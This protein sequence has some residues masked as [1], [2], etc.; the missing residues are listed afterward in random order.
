MANP[1]R[2]ALYWDL[3]CYPNFFLFGYLTDD[4]AFQGWKCYLSPEKPQFTG[5]ELQYLAWLAKT[6][7]WFS[8]NGLNY[9]AP[10][11]RYALT[12]ANTT[13]LKALNDA[14]IVGNLK[15]WEVER[16]GWPQAYVEDWD[17]VDIMEVLP[18]VKIGQKTYMARNHSKTLQD[19]PYPPGTVLTHAQQCDVWNYHNNDLSGLRELTGVVHARLDLRVRLSERYGVDLRSKS[20]AQMSE[21]IIAARLGYRPQVPY[22]L[23]GTRFKLI[24]APWLTFATPYM[25]QVHELCQQVEFE[26]NRKDPGEELP[27]GGKTGVAMPAELKKLRVRIGATDY[28]FGIGG[29]HSQETAR[30]LR[31]PGVRDSDVKAYYP[32]VLERMGLLDPVQQVIYNAIKDERNTHKARAQELEAAGLKGTPEHEEAETGSNGGKIV[33]NGFYG[34]L[35]SK[36]S[37]ALNPQAGVATTING[38]LSLL[39]LIER[40]ELGGVAVRSANTDGIVTHTPAG[41]EW[42]REHVMDWWQAATGFELEHTD[43]RLLAQRDVNSYVAVSTS[44]KIKRK[45]V[46]AESGILSGMQGIHPDRD[47]AKDA[48]VLYM[49][50][51]TPIEQTVRAC[52]DIRKFVLSRKVKGGAYHCGVYLG[53]TARWYYSAG[54][55]EP[56][57]YA[58]GNKV[59]ASDGAQPIQTLP[60]AFPQDVDYAAYIAYAHKL[61][62]D[63]GYVPA[64]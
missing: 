9:D 1:T 11:W 55:T 39:M 16:A 20:D 37:F 50:A 8:F 29:L 15:R 34:K 35:W 56:L 32:T 61:V 33:A 31:G 4:P 2:P 38:Q 36:Y 42:Y 18:G 41:L 22:L 19:L 14:I 47:I 12:G 49:T 59:A 13:Q 57:R 46:F 27:D 43:Y 28:K 53:P 45:G 26:F 62:S 25:Q 17:H 60:D 21:S 51:G 7:T 54:G 23:S 64:L 52:S 3:E 40:L 63:C 6:Y 44:G 5:E 58:N 30:T 48:A 10:M 24:P